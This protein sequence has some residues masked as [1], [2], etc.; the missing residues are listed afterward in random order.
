MCK[1]RRDNSVRIANFLAALLV[2]V[3]VLSL[4]SVI[5]ITA[6]AQL[7]PRTYPTEYDNVVFGFLHGLFIPC[8]IIWSSFNTEVTLS[9]VPNTA[10]YEYGFL[11]G[12]VLC[13]TVVSALGS[14]FKD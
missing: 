13:W 14:L 1:P 8:T 2:V 12:L 4:Y 7:T 3:P 6:V 11:S 5:F 9:Q 10:G